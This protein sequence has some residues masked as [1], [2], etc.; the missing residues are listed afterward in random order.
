MLAQPMLQ[1]TETENKYWERGDFVVIEYQ[2]SGQPN[3]IVGFPPVVISDP[4]LCDTAS[5]HLVNKPYY[6]FTMQ[7]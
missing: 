4:F 5:V 1:V 7:L 6:H 3:H 2:L